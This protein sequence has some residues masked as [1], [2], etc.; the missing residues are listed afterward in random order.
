LARALSRVSLRALS[1]RA[2]GADGA[3]PTDQRPEGQLVWLHATSN[4]RM[5]ALCDLG[6][7][8]KSQ[9]GDV[10]VLATYDPQRV[11]SPPDAPPGC[12]QIIPL[13]PDD[14]HF[15]QQFVRH[16]AP[17]FGLWTGGYLRPNLIIAAANNGTELALVD[18]DE[19]GFEKHRRGWFSDPVAEALTRF[20][21]VMAT[22]ETAA[23]ALQRIGLP[24]ERIGVTAR[25]QAGT[26]PP[27]CADEEVSQVAL[28]LSGRPLWLATF[29]NADEFGP[30]LNAHRHAVR[31]SHR[32]ILVVMLQDHDRQSD[33]LDLLD[34]MTLRH[35]V[36]HLG[37]KIEDHVQ[38][39]VADDPEDLGL[40]YRIS[41]LTFIGCSLVPGL[42]GHSPLG[43]AALGSA[44]IYGPNVKDHIADYTRLASAGAARL[45]RD[46][47]ALGAEVVRLSAPDQAAEMA[48]AGWDTITEGARLTDHLIDLIQDRLDDCEDAD[49]PT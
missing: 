7:R 46:G 4:D 11:L 10:F 43:A 40:W 28:D 41:P 13:A 20:S 33:L 27:P 26:Y 31:L 3:L 9:R 49:A 38:V 45:V 36:W 30:I 5:A 23:G 12:D 6:M 14:P 44:V 48:L 21:P 22:N 16:W 29:V 34:G 18:V 32:L 1:G 8:L 39:L 42:G 47:N 15:A 2:S 17:D 25:L 37:D 19:E 24:A 35:S